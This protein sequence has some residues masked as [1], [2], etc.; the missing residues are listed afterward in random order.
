MRSPADQ[1]RRL[2]SCPEMLRHI[3]APPMTRCVLLARRRDLQYRRAQ[4]RRRLLS[5]VH[6]L[7]VLVASSGCSRPQGTAGNTTM[8]TRNWPP[9]GYPLVQGE[10]RLTDAWSIH[11]PE[12]FAR[13]IE[14]GSLDLWRPGLKLWMPAWGSDNGESQAERLKW[15]KERASPD[16]TNERVTRAGGVTRF[17]Y[18]LVDRNE[19]GEVASLNAVLFGDDEQLQVAAY[20]D[21]EADEATAVQLID[22]IG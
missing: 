22:S 7:C 3:V 5:P 8:R 21:T 20:F 18:R 1:S 17:A 10:H 4:H 11:L 12:S 19:D 16:R 15:V 6:V 9:P 13:R 14:E 2:C